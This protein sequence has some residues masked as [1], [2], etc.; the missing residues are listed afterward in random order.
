M[1][2]TKE[3]VQSKLSTN[4]QTSVGNRLMSLAQHMLGRPYSAFSLDAGPTE[5]LRF[6]LT[7]FDCVLL[8]E[9]LLALVHSKTT[10]DFTRLVKQ[11]RYEDETVDYC[12]RNHYFSRWAINAQRL[13]LIKDISQTLPGSTT[14]SRKLTFMSSHPN[15]YAP[16]K[17]QSTRQ[18]IKS[19]EQKL[20]VNQTYVPIASLPNA[21]RHLK[22]GDIFALVTSVDGLDVTHTGILERTANGLNA[23]HA[24]PDSGV[25]RSVDFVRY[26]AKVEDIIG[27]S[28]FRPNSAPAI[29]KNEA[30]TPNPSSQRPNPSSQRPNP[31]PQRSN[32][33][34]PTPSSNPSNTSATPAAIAGFPSSRRSP[35][36]VTIQAT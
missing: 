21:A 9:Q 23:I 30:N 18:C 5:Q 8:V 11:L 19:L 4:R 36:G 25:V 22:S 27:V 14:R 17:Q 6:D 28:F 35:S 2:D 16:M 34:P 32:T 12:H 3:Q 15:S 7:T 26:A 10:M 33:S 31:S 29:N 20:T 24:V 1:G 13:G